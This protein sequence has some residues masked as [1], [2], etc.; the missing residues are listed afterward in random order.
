[1]FFFFNK[2]FNNKFFFKCFFFK[3]KYNFFKTS[4]KLYLKSFRSILILISYSLSNNNANIFN[5]KQII[6]NNINIDIIFNNLFYKKKLL[7]TI[8]FNS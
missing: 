5:I 7:K 8:I 3:K 6:K 4:L 1:M 2:N